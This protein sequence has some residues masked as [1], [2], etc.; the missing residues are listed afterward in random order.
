[1]KYKAITHNNKPKLTDPLKVIDTWDLLLH[2]FSSNILSMDL[3]DDEGWK[4]SS[5]HL[6][7][8]SSHQLHQ[9]T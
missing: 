6:R 3:Y 5:L 8:T 9:I 2:Q 7:E 1:M 4:H